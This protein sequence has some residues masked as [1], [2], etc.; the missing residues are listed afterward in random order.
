MIDFRQWCWLPRRGRLYRIIEVRHWLWSYR[1]QQNYRWLCFVW[2]SNIDESNY[3]RH[4][5]E[6]MEFLDKL[7]TK[8]EHERVVA[9]R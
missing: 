6:R 4:L 2:W 8:D 3:K 5:E 7:D 9:Q 1:L